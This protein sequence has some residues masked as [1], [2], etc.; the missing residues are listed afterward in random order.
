MRL[1]PLTDEQPK[2][3]LPVANRPLLDYL[4]A[5]VDAVRIPKIYVTL[6]YARDAMQDYL[7]TLS[8]YADL[9]P[10]EAPNWQQGPLAS[11][12]SVLP[13]LSKTT[14]CILLPGDLYLSAENLRL[15]TTASADVALLYD[16]FSHRPGTLL[17]LDS[18]DQI[19]VLTQSSA[20]LAGYYPGLPALRATTQFFEN[21]IRSTPNS[22]STVFTLL[23]QWRLQ[24]QPLQGIP[25][26]D[27]VWCDVDSVT[28]LVAL[29]A[30]LLAEGWPPQPLPPG[31]YLPPGTSMEGPLQSAT[32]TLG[33]EAKI[34][35]PVL[36]GPRV[37]I[38]ENC[39]IDNGTTLGPHTTVY[40]NS[41]L[42]RCI[43]LSDTRVPVNTDLTGAVLDAKGNVLHST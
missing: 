31:T 38:G 41:V 43:T 39:I 42:S 23:Q 18:S 34:E 6:G 8:L 16:P 37:H 40:S 20:Y 2:T 11:F 1:V 36:L 32:L 24:D 10:V 27:R 26:T 17:Q 29:N 25:I 33:N 14:P 15:L 35:G 19:A 28:N 13:F 9:I 4:L 30:H 7:A 21:T 12:Q 3:I 5:A 22:A